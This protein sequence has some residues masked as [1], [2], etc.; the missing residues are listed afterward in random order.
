MELKDLTFLTSDFTC[1]SPVFPAPFIEE[2]IFS[3]MY[4]LASYVKDKVSRQ[5]WI[6][7]WAFNLVP[8][9]YISILCQYHV[10]L[11]TVAL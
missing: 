8:L 11:M 2:A 9:I 1:N 5:A 3:T 7:F 4:F 10:V 6:N